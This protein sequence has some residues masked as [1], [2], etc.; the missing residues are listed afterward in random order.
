MSSV[1]TGKRLKKM[2][3]MRVALVP[4]SLGD[5]IVSVITYIL[6]GLFALLCTY[7]FYYILINTISAN[8]ISANGNILF[9]PQQLHLKNYS[10]VFK[11]PGCG[12]P[13][14]SPWG[15]RFSGRC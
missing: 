3:N 14:R 9:L 15:A 2:K 6:F 12:R 8:D 10:D 1:D 11:L 7:P 4:A 5:Q 13:P